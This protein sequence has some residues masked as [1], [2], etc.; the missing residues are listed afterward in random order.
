[1]S[2]RPARASSRWMAK[3]RSPTPSVEAVW[4]LSREGVRVAMGPFCRSP[5]RAR[6]GP[7]TRVDLV[8]LCTQCRYSYPALARAEIA[9][10]LRRLAN[11]YS[12]LL[13]R[14]DP[15]RLRAHPQPDVWSA[16]EYAC[17]V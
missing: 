15:L 17:H 2:N 16:L 12:E 5:G 6:S 11:S 9:P 13:G 3:L 10:E 8:E 14:A 1:M 4:K 7:V